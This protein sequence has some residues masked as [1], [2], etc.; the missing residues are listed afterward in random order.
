MADEGKMV[1][2]PDVVNEVKEYSKNHNIP[3]D[4]LKEQLRELYFGSAAKFNEKDGTRAR[5]AMLALKAI[6]NARA[7]GGETI[8][9]I[10]LAVTLPQTILAKKGTPDE[11]TM[12]RANII[13]VFNA[14]KSKDVIR[15]AAWDE[16]IEVAKKIPKDK[17]V[18]LTN[19]FINKSEE[20]GVQYT[21]GRS[22]NFTVLDQDEKDPAKLLNRLYSQQRVEVDE[23]ELKPSKDRTDK[24]LVKARVKDSNIIGT[25]TGKIMALY[26]IYDDA[27]SDADLAGESGDDNIYSV[28]CDAVFG[29]YLPGS[30]CLFVGSISPATQQYQASMFADVVV[31][32]MGIEKNQDA[33]EGEVK[34][35]EARAEYLAQEAAKEHAGSAKG[36]TPAEETYDDLEDVTGDVDLSSWDN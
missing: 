11:K 27:V 36:E 5:Q 34:N 18:R 1:V 19:I 25:K 16:A 35:A 14:G 15:I 7:P 6:L 9:G 20:Y 29:K 33:I 10:V 8:E 17:V 21:M 13:G 24:R 32:I 23:F 28:R 4:S 26:R 3:F 12:H 31:P 2:P 30:L 22:S